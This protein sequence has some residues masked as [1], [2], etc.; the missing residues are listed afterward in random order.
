MGIKTSM[1]AS[2]GVP[3]G[4]S[5]AKPMSAKIPVGAPGSAG[6]LA[7]SRAGSFVSPVPFSLTLNFSIGTVSA[8]SI[9]KRTMSFAGIQSLRS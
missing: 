5:L 2:C 7:M 3:A 8:A 1:P 4:F 9:V 6:T